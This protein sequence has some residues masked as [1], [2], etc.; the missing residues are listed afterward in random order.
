MSKE[1]LMEALSNVSSNV[2][3]DTMKTQL[4]EAFDAAVESEVQKKRQSL[5]E[6]MESKIEEFSTVIVESIVVDQKEKFEKAVEAKA[7]TLSESAINEATE[8][9]RKA[10]EESMIQLAESIDALASETASA[11]LEENQ[12]NMTAEAQVLKANAIIESFGEFAGSFGLSLDELSKDE[13]EE[14]ASLK[15][16]VEELQKE[17]D[18][19]HSQFV[20]TQIM[21]ALDESTKGL[22]DLQKEK[23]LALVEAVEFSDYDSYKAKVD[24]YVA[25]F[26]KVRET[27]KSTPSKVTESKKSGYVPSWERKL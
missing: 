18:E 4:S 5:V 15:E 13:N 21:K 1:L 19:L 26:G 14:I 12:I 24:E 11:F 3:S 22:S 16:S 9:I 27:P 7:K 25:V 8:E 20:A 17:R 10:H 6:S 23:V 2:M